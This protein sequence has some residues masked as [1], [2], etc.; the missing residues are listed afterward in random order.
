[1][2]DATHGQVL[3]YVMP[4]DCLSAGVHINNKNKHSSAKKEDTQIYSHNNKINNKTSV[5]AFRC[6]ST[7]VE[8]D[9][10]QSDLSSTT[11]SGA[12][13]LRCLTG[14]L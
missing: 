8:R 14:R 5:P 13:S 9:S 3:P 10:A 11:R 2:L 6:A 4:G 12:N 1:M 7:S